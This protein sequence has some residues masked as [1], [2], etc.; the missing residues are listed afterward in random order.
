MIVGTIYAAIWYYGFFLWIK[1]FWIPTILT[2]VIGFFI[3]RYWIFKE[4][5]K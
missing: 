4:G 3:G 5:V 2:N 1:G